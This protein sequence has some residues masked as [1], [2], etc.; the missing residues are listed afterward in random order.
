MSQQNFFFSTFQTQKRGSRIDSKCKIRSLNPMLDIIGVLRSGGWL[1]F[2]PDN[3][4]V[5]SETFP[6]ILNAKDKIAKLY[7]EHAHS[8]SF[9]FT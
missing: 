3:L 8:I 6:I 5:R 1:Q 9:A 4:E 2:A 7:I